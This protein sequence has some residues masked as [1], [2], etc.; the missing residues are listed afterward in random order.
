M[1]EGQEQVRVG[2][3]GHRDEVRVTDSPHKD[4]SPIVCDVNVFSSLSEEQ[5]LHTSCRMPRMERTHTHTHTL[6]VNV[7][8]IMFNSCSMARSGYRKMPC[9]Q[10][11]EKY[12]GGG[13]GGGGGGGVVRVDMRAKK[14]KV[15]PEQ[16][17][18]KKRAITEGIIPV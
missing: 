11:H 12:D 17:G 9:R 8:I 10:T 14:K 13:G 18:R 3:R 6:T 5:L 15:R 16:N 1:F 2:V 7:T 4:R